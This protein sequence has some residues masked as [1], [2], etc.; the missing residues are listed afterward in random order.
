[1]NKKYILKI[2]SP[3]ETLGI[4]HLMFKP[5]ITQKHY[6]FSFKCDVKRIKYYSS[7]LCQCV[8]GIYVK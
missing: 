3:L 4:F 5:D 7:N 6:D 8:Y 2:L 1:M